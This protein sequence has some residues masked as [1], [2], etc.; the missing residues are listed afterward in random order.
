[1]GSVM[2]HI[3]CPNCK[4]EATLDFYYNTGE[5]YILCTHCGY[6]KAV[7]IDTQDDY[8]DIA[9]A[10]WITEE[11]TNPYGIYKLKHIDDKFTKLG[12]LEDEQHWIDF[13]SEIMSDKDG[14]E[15]FTLSRLV[16]DKIETTTI[17]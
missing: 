6:H 11:L 7:Y 5:E 10:R 4:Q 2:D 3:E 13:V 12:S 1:M 17:I 16:D 8:P 14:I 9:K 15:F